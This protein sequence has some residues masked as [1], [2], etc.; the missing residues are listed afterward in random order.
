MPEDEKVA[1]RQAAELSGVSA[2][3]IVRSGVKRQVEA[4]LKQVDAGKGVTLV[5]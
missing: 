2:T 3:L 4:L 1:L 5:I